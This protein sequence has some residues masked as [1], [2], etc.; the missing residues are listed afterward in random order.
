MTEPI[1]L[2]I[3]VHNNKRHSR[4]LDGSFA[5]PGCTVHPIPLAN[6]EMYSRVFEQ[7][8]IDVGEI[9]IARYASMHSRGECK[10]LALPYYFAREFQHATFYGRVNGEVQHPSQL[11]GRV[12][13]LSE[14]DHTGHTWARALLQDEFGVPPEAAQWVVARREAT[15]PPIR[16]FFQPPANVKLTY[17]P[18]EKYLSQMLLD[19]EI[20]AM[21]N[22]G[23]PDCFIEHPDK[24]RRLIDNHEKE[25]R[26]YFE[27]TGVCP[28]QHVLG[29]RKELLTKHPWLAESLVEAF[30]TAIGP[31]KTIWDP[32]GP[33]DRVP[34]VLL[35]GLG[36]DE[37]S[38]LET[39]LRHH[40]SQGLSNRRMTIEEFFSPSSK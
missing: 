20:D 4:V 31:S 19:G 23:I 22:P 17:A 33:N 6:G 12:I 2:N 26:A 5:L 30:K 24:I 3:A 18:D 32:Q 14:Y 40:Q 37:R 13:G 25:E 16:H 8:N 7:E 27:R 11:A 36:R 9:S 1:S 38:S 34:E 39:F 15:R 21:I 29:V 10:F 28:V 35:Y